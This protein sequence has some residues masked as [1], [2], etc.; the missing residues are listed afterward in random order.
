MNLII[1]DMKVDYKKMTTEQLQDKL[2]ETKAFINELSSDGWSKGLETA[3]EN[4]DEIKRE[5]NSRK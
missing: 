2:S 4:A 1:I 5:L 3:W